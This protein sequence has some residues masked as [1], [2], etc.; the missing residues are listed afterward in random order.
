MYKHFPH[1]M[2][3]IWLLMIVTSCTAAQRCDDLFNMNTYNRTTD[4]VSDED[5]DSLFTDASLTRFKIHCLS[6]SSTY[7]TDSYYMKATQEDVAVR[8][9]VSLTVQCLLAQIMTSMVAQVE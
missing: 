1:K 7:R 2:Y 4:R 5:F 8:D 3:Y 6:L 9:C